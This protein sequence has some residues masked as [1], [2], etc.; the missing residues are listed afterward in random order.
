MKI[1]SVILLTVLLIGCR[2]ITVMED[3]RI[4]DEQRQEIERQAMIISD[5]KEA[6]LEVDVALS[7]AID[8]ARTALGQVYEIKAL[9]D[10]INEF[11]QNIL[12]A[13]EKLYGSESE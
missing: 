4:I 3:Q 8:T 2:H 1:L 10:V 9:F 5:M 11:V 7:T 13:R 6:Q 12:D